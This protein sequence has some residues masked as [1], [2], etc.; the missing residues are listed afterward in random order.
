MTTYL[1]YEPSGMSADL[2]RCSASK[3]NPPKIFCGENYTPLPN[4][5]L[6]NVPPP[7]LLRSGFNSHRRH[8][9]LILFHSLC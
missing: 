9:V 5:C 6:K 7:P 8:R 3:L 2:T 1:I 4:S